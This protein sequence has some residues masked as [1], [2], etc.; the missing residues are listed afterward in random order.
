MLSVLTVRPLF[1]LYNYKLA[2]YSVCRFRARND[3]NL[4]A[5]VAGN[6]YL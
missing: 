6:S 1:K 2:I 3:R 4:S 5:H